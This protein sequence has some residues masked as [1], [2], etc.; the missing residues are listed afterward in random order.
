[1]LMQFCLHQR[2]GA[3]PF[4]AIPCLSSEIYRF[5]IDLKL[6]RSGVSAGT[7]LMRAVGIDRPQKRFAAGDFFFLLLEK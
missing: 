1:M 7:A 3:N 5:A 6:S 4:G 2:T